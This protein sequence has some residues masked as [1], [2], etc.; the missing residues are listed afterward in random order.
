MAKGCIP[1]GLSPEWHAWVTA[2]ASACGVPSPVIVRSSL[3]QVTDSAE[4]NCS[5]SK[6]YVGKLTDAANELLIRKYFNE[7]GQVLSYF[8][9]FTCF[10]S[11]FYRL[12]LLFVNIIMCIFFQA[13][14]SIP[15]VSELRKRLN[16]A[17][18]ERIILFSKMTRTTSTKSI[19][20]RKAI[21]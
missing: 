19:E 20:H 3:F 17:H 8:V 9:E 18:Q 2:R 5:T 7:F 10:I 14:A 1:S 13:I 16:S 11:T 21:L 12:Q 15:L 6:L 4:A